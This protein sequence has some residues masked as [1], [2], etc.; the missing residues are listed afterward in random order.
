MPAG[1]F[2]KSLDSN[3]APSSKKDDLGGFSRHRLPTAVLF[4][5]FSEN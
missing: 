5:P 1:A 2:R 4:L 3:K